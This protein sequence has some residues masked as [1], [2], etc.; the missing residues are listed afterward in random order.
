MRLLIATGIFHPEPGGPASYLYRFLPELLQAGHEVSVLTYGDAPT[1]DY[2]YPVTRIPRTSPIQAR[3]AYRKAAQKLWPG[4]DIAYVHSL[5]L[6]LP[7]QIGPRVIKIVGDTAWER[8]VNKG[9]LDPTSDIDAFQTERQKLHIE[10][11]KWL[12]ARDARQHQHVI[13]PSNYL[14]QMVHGWGV[15][16]EDISVIYNA[17][18]GA[19][20]TPDMSQ[21]EARETLGLTNFPMIFAPARLTGWKGIDHVMRAMVRSGLHILRLVVAGDGPMRT[22]L[23]A[24]AKRLSLTKQVTFVGRVPLHEMPVYYRAADFTVVYSGYEGLSQTIIESLKAGTPVIA[25][26]KGGNPEIVEHGVNGLLAPYIDVDGL[27][28][29]L[30]EAFTTRGKKEEL[31]ANAHYNLDRFDWDNLVSETLHTLEDVYSH[32]Q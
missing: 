15:P 7:R 10:V 24:L 13:V 4:H 30:S 12:R 9:W 1:D 22:D 29:A 11:N 26:Y 16:E 3:L 14:K 5:G 25:S 31:A 23:E 6:P 19:G 20:I 17:V 21:K 32:S 18:P 28:A 8:A 2:P 27:G